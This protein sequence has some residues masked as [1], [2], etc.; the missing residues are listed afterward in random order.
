VIKIGVVFSTGSAHRLRCRG[1]HVYNFQLASTYLSQKYGQKA[2]VDELIRAAGAR[3]L[4]DTRPVS[5]ALELLS[6]DEHRLPILTGA[7]G[8]AS[9]YCA[10]LGY[11][12]ARLG[13]DREAASAYE[14]VQADP[15]VDGVAKANWSGW[16]VQYYQTQ[17]QLGP[18]LQLA[19][20]SAGTGAFAAS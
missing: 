18:A 5:A 11:E 7:C 20:R 16:L 19:E 2:P 6:D 13:R 10:S 9:S 1:A 17:G 12:Q 3:M 4:Y 14:R 8:F 15:A